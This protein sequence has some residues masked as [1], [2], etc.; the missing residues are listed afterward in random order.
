MDERKIGDREGKR[1]R[2]RQRERGGERER[3]IERDRAEREGGR[4]REREREKE[5]NWIVKTLTYIKW[6]CIDITRLIKEIILLKQNT[7][8]S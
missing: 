6:R 1:E 8:N 4:E 7:N 3:Q 5:K 2:E